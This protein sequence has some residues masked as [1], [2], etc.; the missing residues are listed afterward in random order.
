MNTTV[1]ELDG[2]KTKL[3]VEVDEALVDEATEHAWVHIAKEI[4]VKGFRPGKVPPRVAKAQIPAEY[5]R[6]EALKTV[7][8]EQ[9][10]IALSDNDI[11]SIDQ[12][13]VDITSGE[14]AGHLVFDAIVSV[15]PKV[16]VS[17]F[18][19]ITVEVPDAVPNDDEVQDRIDSFLENFSDFEPVDRAAEPGDFVV[20]ELAAEADGEVIPELTMEEYRYGLGSGVLGEAADNSIEGLR[21]G[22]TVE[23]VGPHPDGESGD[24]EFSVTVKE[25]QGKTS[26]ELTDELL[27]DATEFETVD[28]F[29]ESVLAEL[30]E[31]RRVQI[32]GAAQEGLRRRLAE[33]VEDS[34]PEKLVDSALG[35]RL[36]SLMSR[37][38][39]MGIELGQYLAMT[40]T[41]EQTF[42]SENR[43]DAE[44]DVRTQLALSAIA[45]EQGLALSEE[46]LDEEIEKIAGDVELSD[47][48]ESLAKAG[49]LV[50]FKTT[51][52]QRRAIDWL[53]DTVDFV[54]SDG[55]SVDRELVM[56]PDPSELAEEEE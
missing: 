46:E 53:M 1:E 49:Q 7:I 6:G 40:G 23:F 54:T 28:E 47:A 18:A 4:K 42:V 13:E 37:F 20:I 38:S 50:G 17:G 39:Q 26:P 2:N 43:V 16:Q 29:R 11:E 14:E 24:V 3:T 33:L 56:Q 25:V 10:N 51:I 41:D 8:P 22:D 35:Q 31:Q 12:P 19:N 9:F 44:A 45:K 30:T 21:A 27:A 55:T 34:I 15:M 52:N 5:A 36:N 48:R 32:P